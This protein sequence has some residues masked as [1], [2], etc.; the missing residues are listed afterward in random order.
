MV[1]QAEERI[2]SSVKSCE[3]AEARN[4]QVQEIGKVI[5]GERMRWI[6]KSG[7]FSALV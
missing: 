6:A 1:W 2:F 3:R 4:R 5:Y 7:P